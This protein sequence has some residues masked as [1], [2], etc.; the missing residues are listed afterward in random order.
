M[1]LIFGLTPI[2]SVAAILCQLNS[3]QEMKDTHSRRRAY[4]RPYTYPSTAS[5]RRAP[6]HS[7]SATQKSPRTDPADSRARAWIRG[8]SIGLDRVREGDG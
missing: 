1:L 8:C 5:Q 6:D 7:P 3:E 4:P 2:G